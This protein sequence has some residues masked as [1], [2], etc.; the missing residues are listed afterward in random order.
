MTDVVCFVDL[1]SPWKGVVIFCRERCRGPKWQNLHL[2]DE[3][4]VEVLLR[5][6][7]GFWQTP[8][9]LDLELQAMDILAASRPGGNVGHWSPPL[10]SP[11]SLHK[12]FCIPVPGADLSPPVTLLALN[13]KFFVDRQSQ[14]RDF[15]H[16]LTSAGAQD[17]RPSL[18]GRDD[19]WQAMLIDSLWKIVEADEA[20][21]KVKRRHTN[22][23]RK[24]MLPHHVSKLKTMQLPIPDL[25]PMEDRIHTELPAVE[26]DRQDLQQQSVSLGPH[27]A[28]LIPQIDQQ[29]SS[30]SGHCLPFIPP[31]P[32]DCVEETWLP[33][34]RLNH[35]T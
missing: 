20:H 14:F 5:E 25:A 2:M 16:G 4:D 29:A 27:P 28:V 10:P 31:V 13:R 3:E 33:H 23:S 15:F 30:H 26:E 7:V 6:D 22:Y 1:V 35:A 18:L 19:W 21:T 32:L 34:E 9:D 11:S 8:D 24:V 17:R 12:S